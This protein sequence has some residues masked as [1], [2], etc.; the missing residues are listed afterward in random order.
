MRFCVRVVVWW[1]LLNLVVAVALSMLMVVWSLWRLWLSALLG[2]APLGPGPRVAVVAQ[3]LG[4][5]GLPV[6][7]VVSVVA[8]LAAAVHAA[9]RPDGEGS[10]LERLPLLGEKV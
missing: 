7:A 4:V 10:L 9:V 1:V 3:G 5:W 2:G 8:I 6:L